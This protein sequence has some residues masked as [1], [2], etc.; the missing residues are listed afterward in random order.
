MG[1]FC[2]PELDTYFFVTLVGRLSF[3][4]VVG[5]R[6]GEL[7]CAYSW[8]S[9]EKLPT[10]TMGKKT[11]ECCTDHFVPLVA[12]RSNQLLHLWIQ[13]QPGE[14]MC[15]KRKWRKQCSFKLLELLSEEMT[16]DDAERV[17][18]SSSAETDA[19]GDLS[20]ERGK[21]CRINR[22]QRLHTKRRSQSVH[23]F[24]KGSEL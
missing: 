3:G 17:R 13:V 20:S 19:G 10:F 6:C 11:L 22:V 18:K 16:N 14:N 12:E 5:R 2:I 21:L 15:P 4:V 9:I 7:R 1:K 23:A 8:Q 24:P